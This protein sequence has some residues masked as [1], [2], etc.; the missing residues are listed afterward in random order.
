[1]MCFHLQLQKRKLA[2]A[3]KWACHL[4]EYGR[5]KAGTAHLATVTNKQKKKKKSLLKSVTYVA[6]SKIKFTSRLLT[7]HKFG[8]NLAITLLY[9]MS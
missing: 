5:H 9:L 3:G 1:M 8:Y 6:D 2:W 4:S 7:N